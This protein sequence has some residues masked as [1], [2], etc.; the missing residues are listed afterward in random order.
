V[1]LAQEANVLGET[2]PVVFV[3]SGVV[4]GLYC[5]VVVVNAISE[6]GVKNGWKWKCALP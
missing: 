3:W 2:E 5:V 1:V 4:D 6:S